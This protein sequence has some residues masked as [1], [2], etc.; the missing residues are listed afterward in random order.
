MDVEKLKEVYK[1]LRVELESVRA[2]ALNDTQQSNNKQS[3]SI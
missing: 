3:F 1:E 2:A